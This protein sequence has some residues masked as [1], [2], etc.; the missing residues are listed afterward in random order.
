MIAKVAVSVPFSNLFDYLIPEKYAGILK[1]GYRVLVPFGSRG[2]IGVVV[3]IQPRSEH[4]NLKTITEVVDQQPIFDTRVLL[5]TKWVSEYYLSSWGEVLEAALPAGLKYKVEKQVI[6]R[7][8]HSQIDTLNEKQREW[9]LSVDRKI[10]SRL[11]KSEYEKA[12]KR[13]FYGVE[14]GR[15]YFL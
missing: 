7:Q 13:L 3:E 8:G 2:L 15:G 9:L 14:K 11:F 12:F 4:D 6:V 1:A 5:F 10:Y